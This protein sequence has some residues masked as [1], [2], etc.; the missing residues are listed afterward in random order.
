M[1]RL[2]LSKSKARERAEKKIKEYSPQQHYEFAKEHLEERYAIKNL[3]LIESVHLKNLTN[4]CIKEAIEDYIYSYMNDKPL[5]EFSPSREAAERW[6]L[7]LYGIRLEDC[8]DYVRIG[9][10]ETLF[11]G[12]IGQEVY[13]RL[14]YPPATLDEKTLKIKGYARWESI[15]PQMKDHIRIMREKAHGNFF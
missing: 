4:I 2:K 3:S 6:L 7:C 14:K 5:V 10:F 12:S 1:K 8:L 9:G 13:Q 15:S 11:E